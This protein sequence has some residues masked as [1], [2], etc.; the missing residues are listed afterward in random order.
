MLLR[1]GKEEWIFVTFIHAPVKIQQA[2]SPK[3][4]CGYWK[5]PSRLWNQRAYAS[6]MCGSA[7]ESELEGCEELPRVAQFQRI[8]YNTTLSS[9]T[10]PRELLSLLMAFLMCC[11]TVFSDMFSFAAISLLDRNSF[12]LKINTSRHFKGS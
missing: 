10:F 6:C 5:T 8:K 7:R 11:S 9:I 12:L 3:L 4:R 1:N 2:R